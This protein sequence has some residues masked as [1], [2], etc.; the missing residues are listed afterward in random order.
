LASAFSIADGSYDFGGELTGVDDLL[1]DISE[2]MRG[3]IAVGE[4][5]GTSWRDWVTDA[6]DS[7][8]TFAEG[9]KSLGDRIATVADGWAATFSNDLVSALETGEN[10]FKSFADSVIKQLARIALQMALEPLFSSFGSLFSPGAGAAAAGAGAGAGGARAAGIGLLNATTPQ[11]LNTKNIVGTPIAPNYG[12]L[13]APAASRGAVNVTVNNNANAEVAVNQRQTA[14]GM[15]LEIAVER[16]V[17][18]RI[19]QG[20]FDRAMNASYGLGRRGY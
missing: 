5:L 4:E 1:G 8:D 13:A 9:V 10:A 11:T 18:D 7:T 16:L 12:S 19:Q 2:T 14:N 6:S 20:A 17:N 3:Q 15:E